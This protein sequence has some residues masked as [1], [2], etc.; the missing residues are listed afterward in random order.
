MKI[1]I[2]NIIIG[3]VKIPKIAFQDVV[4]AKHTQTL[5]SHMNTF[6]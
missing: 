4:C 1:M 5:N 6:Y 2:K 3:L